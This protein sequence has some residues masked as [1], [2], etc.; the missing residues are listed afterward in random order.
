M[1][2]LPIE[3]KVSKE[4][5]AAIGLL[6][7]RCCAIERALTLQLVRASVL[8]HNAQN[9]L[10]PFMVVSGMTV[11]TMLGLL[12]SVIR[13]RFPG[14]ADEFDKL[15]DQLRNAFANRRDTIAHK[16]WAAGSKPDRI[17]VWQIRTVG[18]IEFDTYEPCLSG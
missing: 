13:L 5:L 14:H 7:T 9:Y 17:K 10:V 16:V 3:D 18:K 6:M 8:N 12:K 1:I 11:P 4:T 15:A 2:D